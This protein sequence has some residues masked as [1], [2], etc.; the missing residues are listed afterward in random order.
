MLMLLALGTLYAA[1]GFTPWAWGTGIPWALFLF[2]ALGFAAFGVVALG[3]FKGALVRSVW[4]D[5]ATWSLFALLAVS[6]L[7]GVVSVHRG[8]SLEAMLNLLAISGLF[9]AA[10][11]FLRGSR[12]LRSVAWVQLLAAVPVAAIGLAQYFRPDLLPASNSYPGR[13]LGPFGQ[14]NRLGGYLIAVIPVAL[15]LAFTTQDRW[16]RTALLLGVLA[17][18]MCLIVT[19]SRGAWIGLLASLVFLAAAMIRWPEL[20]PRGATLAIAAAC[21]VL[22]TL[23]FLPAVL[24]RI[25]PKTPDAAAW[26]LPFDPEREGSG[27]MRR[28]IWSGAVG[29]ARARPILGF[30]IGTFREAFDRVKDDRMKRLEAEGTRT[31]D[32]AHNQYL[33]V[34]AERGGLGLAGF[35]ALAAVCLAAAGA[36]VASAHA[37]P[38]ARWIPL[39]FAGGAIALLTHAALDGNLSLVPHQTLFYADLGILSAAAP[40]A[41]RRVGRSALRGTL[42]LLLA[43]AGL[44]VSSASFAASL[45]AGDGAALA[46]A[47]RPAEAADALRS[48]TRLDP[49]NDVYSIELA[50]AEEQLG[51]REQRPE[52]LRDAESAYRGAIR[53]NGSDPVTRQELARLYL[54]HPDVWGA[55]GAAKARSLLEAALAQN[56]YYAEIRNDLGVALLRS[57]DR[58][59]AEREFRQASAGR[60]DFVDPILNLATMSLQSGDSASARS[61]VREALERAPDSARARSLASRLGIPAEAGGAGH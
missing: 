18:T 12:R 8:K 30:G 9:L 54:A 4:V 21:I 11:M 41:F 25:A 20:A 22:P 5:R 7:S 14:P 10:A 24:A 47:D 59:G 34:L 40:G 37:G 49:W 43:G 57:G 58:A 48:A 61:L 35:L 46:R 16:L 52:R 44:C 38:A 53:A 27:A 42:G 1:I 51:V 60:I 19:F 17:L 33:E 45:A 36:A 55:S 26:N 28:E 50:R 23:L 56:P 29:A 39:G 13:A 6:I 31:A 32:N 2:R 3:Q 15:A